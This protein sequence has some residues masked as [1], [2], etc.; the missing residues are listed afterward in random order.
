MMMGV[1][2]H[3]FLEAS[4]ALAFQKSVALVA[5]VALGDSELLGFFLFLI[6][7]S[8]VFGLAFV[9]CFV[10]FLSLDSCQIL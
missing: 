5:D 8:A 10:V 2:I 9:T 1:H 7:S 6:A 3:G 4:S